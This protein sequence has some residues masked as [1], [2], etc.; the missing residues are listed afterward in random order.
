MSRRRTTAF[1]ATLSLLPLGQPLLLG[2]LGIT[3]A[4]TAVVL[5][6]SPA[7]AQDASAV[8]RIAKA[9]TVRIEGATQGSG[10]LVK[11]EGNRYTVLTAWHVVESNRPGEELAIER[12]ISRTHCV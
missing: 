11:K 8:A 9:I 3:T 6:Q 2:T 4:T 10:V 12:L 7:F 1:A 5:Q